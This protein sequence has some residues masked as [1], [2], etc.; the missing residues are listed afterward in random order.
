MLGVLAH[1]PYS[2]ERLIS[3]LTKL[4]LSETGASED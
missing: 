1:A 3:M 2:R 4:Y